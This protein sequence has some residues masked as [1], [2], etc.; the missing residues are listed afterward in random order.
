MARISVVVMVD[1]EFKFMERCI[2]SLVNQTFEDIEIIFNVSN[3]NDELWKSIGKYER[4]DRRIRS[5]SRNAF[6]FERISGKYVY[7]ISSNEYL[8]FNALENLHDLSEANS[9]DLIFFKSDARHARLSRF[10]VFDYRDI[11]EDIFKL[12]TSLSTKFF[13]YSLLKD[14]AFDELEDN[15]IYFYYIFKARRIMFCNE[16]LCCGSGGHVISKNPCEVIEISNYIIDKI[17]LGGFWEIFKLQLLYFKMYNIYLSFNNV[18]EDDKKHFM[19]YVQNDLNNYRHVLK[20]RDN[21]LEE[22]YNYILD[23]R[24]YD[25]FERMIKS[26]I[27]IHMIKDFKD[28]NELLIS[29]NNYNNPKINNLRE[30]WH[31]LIFYGLKYINISLNMIYY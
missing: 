22:I 14:F 27:D 15:L 29:K 28:F 8:S 1:D 9:L 6:D 10:D 3:S 18:C 4:I 7:F 23:C 20:D 24:N 16:E 17:K 5:V 2:E 31:C 26:Y 30:F 25:E 12:D 19:K 11:A 13:R 21:D